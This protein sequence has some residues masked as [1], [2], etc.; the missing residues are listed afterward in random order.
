MQRRT[1]IGYSLLLFSIIIFIIGQIWFLISPESQFKAYLV[2][3]YKEALPTNQCEDVT[4]NKTIGTQGVNKIS[5]DGLSYAI[6]D[7]DMISHV[8]GN[9]KLYKLDLHL[10][11]LFVTPILPADNI[12]NLKIRTKHNKTINLNLKVT[13][14][15][16]Q[17]ITLDK[18][19]MPLNPEKYVISEIYIQY[20]WIV[21][22]FFLL[23]P[24]II[25]DYFKQRFGEKKAR[26]KDILAF[27]FLGLVLGGITM[28]LMGI[29]FIK[30][31]G[32]ILNLWH[33]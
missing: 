10:M 5:F 16:G 9:K 29:G 8:D 17:E 23:T 6:G 32:K 33:C 18:E 27:I 24:L 4:I 20:I 19:L 22:W 28:T 26:D 21:L 7:S 30:L 14:K 2:F 31:I 3:F 15:L 11:H 13:D 1:Y 25:F 12:L